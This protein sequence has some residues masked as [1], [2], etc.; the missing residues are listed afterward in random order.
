MKPPARRYSPIQMIRWK[1]LD[2]IVRDNHQ[3]DDT[4]L[5]RWFD[6]KELD[7]IVRDKIVTL[8]YIEID[9]HYC[10]QMNVRAETS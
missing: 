2:W 7:G 8:V 9:V 4:V 3:P 10:M 6:G 5:L 1:E